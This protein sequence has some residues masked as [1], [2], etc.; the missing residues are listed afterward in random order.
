MKD[1]NIV[2]EYISIN[3]K[4]ELE[5]MYIDCYEHF[6]WIHIKNEEKKDYYINNNVN[7]DI[8]NIKFKRDRMISNKE[9]LNELQ[10]KCE[11][12]FLKINRLEKEPVF[13]AISYA[14]IIGM[15]GI[16]FAIVS[17]FSLLA[18]NWFIGIISAIIA[19]IG[20][21]LPYLVYKRVKGNKTV[22]NKSKINSEQ[23]LILAIFKQ[24]KEILF[25][26]E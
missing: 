10:K 1:E 13:F 12:A 19:I 6:G 24:A 23:D 17:I 2:Y 8:V 26:N 25:E 5:P 20:F 11:K 18:S 7:Q 9:E 22:E 16:L 14:L 3:V 15:I 4:S 21:I